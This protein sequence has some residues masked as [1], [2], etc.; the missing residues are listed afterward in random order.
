VKPSDAL[1]RAV[2]ASNPQF[3]LYPDFDP[4]AEPILVVGMPGGGGRSEN[5]IWTMINSLD[6]PELT[7]CLVVAS[8]QDTQS[9]GPEYQG[10]GDREHANIFNMSSTSVQVM[11]RFV[12]TVT[13]A[14]AR[15]RAARVATVR[16]RI[17]HFLSGRASP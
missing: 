12:S 2:L 14:Q 15:S 10:Q 17:G 3:Y 1:D 13:V 5:F 16:V 4:D 7:R 6:R 8:I 9:G 11:T